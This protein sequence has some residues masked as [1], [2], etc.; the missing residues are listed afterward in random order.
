LKVLI[1]HLGLPPSTINFID[2]VNGTVDRVKNTILLNITWDPPYPYGELEYYELFLTAEFNVTAN[3][4]FTRQTYFVS[5]TYP[6]TSIFPY[7]AC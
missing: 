7:K 3:H 5:Y 1:T 4:T 2:I 6:T